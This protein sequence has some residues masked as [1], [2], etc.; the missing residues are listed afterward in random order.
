MLGALLFLYFFLER[1]ANSTAVQDGLAVSLYCICVVVCFVLSKIFHT[2][3]DHSPGMHKFGNE[4][5]HLGIVL[6]MWGTGIS[7]THFA[8][9][10][11]STIRFIYFSLLSAAAIAYGLLTLKPKFRQPAYRTTR[12]SIYVSLGAGL[13]A[14]LVHGI[15]TF[16][17][18]NLDEMMGLGS[19]LG[20]SIINFCG[21]AVYAA[22]IPERWFPED[23]II[24]DKVTTGCTYLCS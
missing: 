19:F 14:P 22:R 9:R 18:T 20:L 21:A 4:L 15:Y 7:G 3:S 8:F 5:D 6:V 10:C 1:L 12:F 11:N 16:G 17:W 23:L 24:L 13:F 2:F